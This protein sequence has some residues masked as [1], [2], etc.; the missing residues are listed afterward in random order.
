MKLIKNPLNLFLVITLFTLSTWSEVLRWPSLCSEPTL[1]LQNLTN[2]EIQTWLQTFQGPHRIETALLIPAQKRIQ[3]NI[4]ADH[5]KN[6]RYALLHLSTEVNPVQ[7]QVTCD[8][9]TYPANNIEGGVLT[10]RKTDLVEPKILLQ[11]LFSAET[12]FTIEML[13]HSNQIV[14][15]QQLT[16]QSFEMQSF[17]PQVLT[18]NWSSLR[19]RAT[20]RFTA[21]NL[22]SRG[23]ENPK[24]IQPEKSVI[25]KTV[26]YFLITPRDGL[27]D[28]FTVKIT[29]PA[30]I[31]KA[32][33]LI[34]N[35][36]K[37][38]MLF[39]TIE[40]GAQGF[41]RNFKKSEKSFWS[42][43]T[44]EVTNFAD[45]GSTACNGLPQQVEDDVDLWVQNPGRICFWNYRVKKEISASEVESPKATNSKQLMP[46][47]PESLQR[48]L[49]LF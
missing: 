35:P 6:D 24:M 5:Q 4:N 1:I 7:A 49:V 22:S 25:D 42:W 44:T 38:K 8:Q 29:H 31:E 27:G 12:S 21:F 34:Q 20:N 37:E 19:V 14:S 40:K 10:F 39:A 18:N 3:L 41:N 36:Q 23:S 32:L 43:S 33:D 11:N 46:F 13:N 2:H 30:M 15:T 28:S 48:S 16:L 47:V 17:K 45:L 9:L 26:R